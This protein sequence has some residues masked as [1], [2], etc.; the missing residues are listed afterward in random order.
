MATNCKADV[1]AGPFRV[2]CTGS[3]FYPSGRSPYIKLQPNP[4][5]YGPK[6]KINVLIPQISD[7]TTGY[8]EYLSGQ[9][10]STSIPT[11]EL[12]AAKKRKS[13]Y[14]SSP[15][16]AIAYVAMNTVAPPFN[17][18]NCRLAV[19]YGINRSLIVKVLHGAPAPLYTVLPQA[20]GFPGAVK[21]TAHPG[22]IPYYNP[23]KSKQYFAKCKYTGVVKYTYNH[24]S[25]DSDNLAATIVNGLATAGFN[26]KTDP[27]T[28]QDWEQDISHPMSQSGLVATN[29]GWIQDY[30]DPQDY[31]DNL[32]TCTA[33]ENIMSWCNKT[34]DSLVNKADY[35]TSNATRA[36]LYQ[37]AEQILLAKDAAVAPYDTVPTRLLW[38]SKIHG[39]TLTVA[40]DE[41]FP[42]NFDWSTV[43]VR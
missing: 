14:H 18:V 23:T 26:A 24:S 37:Q 1:G 13:E 2:V 31:M 40:Y 11:A 9:L 7:V 6:P 10:D 17:N 30:P 25:V 22:S 12:A 41:A 3:S 5:Y 36:K 29:Y 35:S 19:A 43:S 39:L 21:N 32:F 33:P 27:I 38:K 4:Y 16:S 34:F 28:T 15:S 42:K 20:P 8:R